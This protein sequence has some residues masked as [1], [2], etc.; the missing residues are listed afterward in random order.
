MYKQKTIF[1]SMQNSFYFQ[2][3]MILI[4]PFLYTND[5]V[6]HLPNYITR[7][8][9]IWIN[10]V[11]NLSVFIKEMTH[12]LYKMPSLPDDGGVNQIG[13]RKTKMLVLNKMKSRAIQTKTEIFFFVETFLIKQF[14]LDASFRYFLW[15]C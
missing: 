9:F 15:S 7:V 12:Y 6:F 5:F 10:C 3:L 13:T 4:G 1:V 8:F 2:Q 14:C 11:F